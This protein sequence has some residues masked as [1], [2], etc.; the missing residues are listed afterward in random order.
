MQNSINLLIQKNQELYV[1]KIQL[2]RKLG[3]S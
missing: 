3:M 2:K 1:D